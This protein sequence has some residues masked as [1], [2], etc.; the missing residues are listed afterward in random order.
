MVLVALYV[1][2]S[3]KEVDAALRWYYN[4]SIPVREVVLMMQEVQRAHPGTAFLFEGID[5]DLF[6]TVFT[7][8]PFRIVGVERVYFVP[9]GEKR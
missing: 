3:F 2:C 4:R 9:G 5:N 6:H 8:N 1:T 7:N